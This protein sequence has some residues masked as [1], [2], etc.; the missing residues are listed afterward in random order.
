VEVLEISGKGSAPPKSGDLSVALGKIPPS[1]AE[2]SVKALGDL[3]RAIEDSSRE[4]LR[5]ISQRLVQ[6]ESGVF[7]EG[8]GDEGG[9]LSASPPVGHTSVS[10]RSPQPRDFPLSYPNLWRS[11]NGRDKGHSSCKQIRRSPKKGLEQHVGPTRSRSSAKLATEPS[12]SRSA[13][14]R[15]SLGLENASR[16]PSLVSRRRRKRQ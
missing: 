11:E 7:S 6:L 10:S 1:R 8:N 14:S 4:Q 9:M 5:E 2:L 16:F 13:S 15:D 12:G 3:K